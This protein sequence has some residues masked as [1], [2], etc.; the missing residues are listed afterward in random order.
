MT[1]AASSN[2]GLSSKAQKSISYY[3]KMRSSRP[4][5]FK[6]LARQAKLAI[7]AQKKGKTPIETAA[8]LKA[9][10]SKDKEMDPRTAPDTYGVRLFI[11]AMLTKPEERSKTKRFYINVL[12]ALLNKDKPETTKQSPDGDKFQMTTSPLSK[13]KKL[14]TE[15]LKKIVSEAA[16]MEMLSIAK[17]Q[18]RL[19]ETAQAYTA[20]VHFLKEYKEVNSKKRLL[21]FFGPFKKLKTADLASMSSAG[22][23]KRIAQKVKAAEVGRKRLA[24]SN[25]NNIPAFESAFEGYIDA[26]VEL[27]KDIGT[28]GED[29][30]ERLKAQAKKMFGTAA[31]TLQTLQS[32]LARAANE[33]FSKVPRSSGLYGDADAEDFQARTKSFMQSPAQALGSMASRALA[34]AGGTSGRGGR[35]S[36]SQAEEGSTGAPSR[37]GEPS[38]KDTRK[39]RKALENK[40]KKVVNLQRQYDKAYD[41]ATK[42]HSDA[43]KNKKSSKSEDKN[44]NVKK[45]ETSTTSPNKE[46]QYKKE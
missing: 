16:Y 11:D 42:K 36:S 44:K 2:K 30:D 10:L 3:R 43:D 6:A 33:L 37:K 15:E 34:G 19:A 26:L 5:L 40:P 7:E 20:K 4:A 14:T 21:E 38:M 32:S 8:L 23:N 45:K 22:S 39:E 13:Q 24:A 27:Y 9:L 28:S 35:F 18:L 25:I 31:F 29:V 12:D 17:D 1:N 46:K 41:K